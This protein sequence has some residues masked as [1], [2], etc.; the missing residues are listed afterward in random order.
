[1]IRAGLIVAL[2][3][4]VSVT[5]VSAECAWVLWRSLMKIDP[6][7][8]GKLSK[9]EVVWTISSAFGSQSEC[10]QGRTIAASGWRFYLGPSTHQ[11]PHTR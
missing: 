6:E 7:D 1:M 10:S 3:R 4:F 9:A 8:T 11:A 2:V 5:S